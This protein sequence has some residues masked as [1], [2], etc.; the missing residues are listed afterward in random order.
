MGII[1]IIIRSVIYDDIEG[2]EAIRSLD[3]LAHNGF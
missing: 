2:K 3:M 1:T